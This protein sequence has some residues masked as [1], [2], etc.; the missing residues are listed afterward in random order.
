MTR[1]EM[2]EVMARGVLVQHWLDAGCDQEQAIQTARTQELFDGDEDI[3]DDWSTE[4]TYQRAALSA[5]EVA[6]YVVVPREPTP[7]MLDAFI[8]DAVKCDGL[9]DGLV[10]D[11]P[12]VGYAAML[13]AAQQ[14][15]TDAG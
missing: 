5:L 3:G 6:G 14:E 4:L 12:R 2:I 9:C 13:S 15:K 10:I 11:N 8:E 1:D 7:E